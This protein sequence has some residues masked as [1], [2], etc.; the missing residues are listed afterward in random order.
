MMVH[1]ME[2]LLLISVL[3]IVIIVL[4]FLVGMVF[5]AISPLIAEFSKTSSM[6]ADIFNHV[7]SYSVWIFGVSL[8]GMGA[9]LVA[10]VL[11]RIRRGRT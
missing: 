3:V 6:S 2:E 1:D 9:I 8:V 5:F 7:F 4:A 11:T 10:W